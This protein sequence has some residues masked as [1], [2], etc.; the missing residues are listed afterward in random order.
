[1]PKYKTAKFIYRCPFHTCDKQ[2]GMD[3]SPSQYPECHGAHDRI[4][5][6]IE[7][8]SRAVPSHITKSNQ[9]PMASEFDEN[10]KVNGGNW[11]GA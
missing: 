3:V 7:A 6:F 4:M 8:E 11:I 2:V 10:R 1:M 5:D 9:K